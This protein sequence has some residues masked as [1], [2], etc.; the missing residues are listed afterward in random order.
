VVNVMDAARRAG[1]AKLT[2]ATQPRKVARPTD[3]IVASPQ[4]RRPFSGLADERP[5]AWGLLPV[6]LIF[7][8]LTALRRVFIA[9][10]SFAANDRRAGRRRRNLM[11]AA[12][13]D[14]DGDGSGR[15]ASLAR[16]HAR[17]IS[18]GYGRASNELA[19]VSR[20]PT[21][22]RWRRATPDALRLQ[23][24]V[25]VGPIGRRGTKLLRLHPATDVIVTTTACSTCVCIETASDGLRP[26]RRRQ[27]LAA[28]AVR[29][30]NLCHRVCRRTPSCS[31][32]RP[33]RRPRCPHLGSTQP[34]RRVSLPDW[35]LG[36]P[37]LSMDS[38]NSDNDVVAAAG[39]AHP[40]RFFDMLQS[41]GL[42]SIACPARSFRLRDLAMAA[43]AADVLVT[44]KDAVK[45][46]PERTGTTR[47]WVV[48]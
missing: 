35:W 29:C 12:R 5:L 42:T 18:R 28:A 41:A 31:T 1:L 16:I 45:L 17:V 26:A 24:P 33:V 9:W 22:A 21:C 25:V 27:R 11:P 43:S 19:D 3:T 48:R 20:R 36:R 38:M 10:V 39:M 2:F 44:E 8:A 15:V 47:V 30:A 13:K 34:A 14:P 40:D 7:S 6:G 32:T 37:L 4:A 23:Q 46:K